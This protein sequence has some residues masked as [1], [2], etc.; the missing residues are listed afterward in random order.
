MTKILKRSHLYVSCYH[1]SDPV[2]VDIHCPHGEASQ[3]AAE[4]APLHSA[5]STEIYTRVFA[6]DVA[7]RLP[8]TVSDAGQ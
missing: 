1:W 8:G 7:A 5:K 6:L 2:P 4:F 3:G